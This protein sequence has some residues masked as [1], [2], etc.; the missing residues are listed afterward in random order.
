MMSLKK[1]VTHVLV[2]LFVSSYGYAGGNYYVGKDEG[3]IYLQTDSDGG[4]Y[5]DQIDLKHFTIGESGTYRTGMDRGGQFILIDN[6]KYYI[7]S[8]RKE[9]LKNEI[10]AFNEKQEENTDILKTPVSIDGN[11]VLVPV[12]I[13]HAGKTTNVNLLLD[14][15]ASVVTLHRTVIDKLKIRNQKK[16]RMQLAGGQLIDAHIARVDD[17]S[18]GPNKKKDVLVSIIEQIDQN[19]DYDGLLGMNFLRNLRYEIDFE[20]SVIR[21][22]R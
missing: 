13:R 3:G 21:W 9:S 12:T 7:D 5:I 22:Y 14:T 17:V 8:N 20:N 16:T 1:I 4:W 11:R 19:A 2:L 6:H 10:A 15:G 18:V